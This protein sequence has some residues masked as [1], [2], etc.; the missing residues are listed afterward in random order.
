MEELPPAPRISYA[1]YSYRLSVPAS[2]EAPSSDEKKV[3]TSPD[4]AQLARTQRLKQLLVGLAPG[5]FLVLFALPLRAALTHFQL[6]SA[7]IA[8]LLLVFCW[9]LP[10]CGLVIALIQMVRQERR[11]LWF[12]IGLFLGMLIYIPFEC[13]YLSTINILVY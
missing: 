7:L 1:Q 10:F 12:G 6:D 5:L 2:D 8:G 9:L 11:Q 3:P 13:M 4:Y